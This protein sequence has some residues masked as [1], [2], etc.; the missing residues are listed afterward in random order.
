MTLKEGR[1]ALIEV[2]QI[3]IGLI[4]STSNNNVV[5]L[6]E[7]VWCVNDGASPHVNSSDDQKGVSNQ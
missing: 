4:S 5:S 2:G 1:P 3:N 6:E 7:L